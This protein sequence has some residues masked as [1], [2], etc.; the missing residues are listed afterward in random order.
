MNQWRRNDY[1]RRH[2]ISIDSEART[3]QACVLSLFAV[4][5]AICAL[6]V[7]DTAAQDT[8]TTTTTVVKTTGKPTKPTK[9]PKCDAGNYKNFFQ[10][11]SPCCKTPPGAFFVYNKTDKSSTSD[12]AAAKYCGTNEG[13]LTA[14][15]NILTLNKYQKVDA[16]NGQNNTVNLTTTFF[17]NIAKDACA[18]NCYLQF[19]NAS[20][21]NGTL[22]VSAVAQIFLKYQNSTYWI[23]ALTNVFLACNSIITQLSLPTNLTDSKKRPCFF[24]AYLTAQCVNL[25][26]IVVFKNL[27]ADYVNKNNNFVSLA[28]LKLEITQRAVVRPC[29]LNSITAVNLSSLAL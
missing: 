6:S 14:A 17:K 27:A 18:V 15:F 25:L 1:K 21:A 23:G 13:S 29:G 10:G 20:D 2:L 9:P 12:A 19:K 24:D 16:K 7:F 8:T 11:K 28:L 5:L 26:S 4:A 22:D 3:M